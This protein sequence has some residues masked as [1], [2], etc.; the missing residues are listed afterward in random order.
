MASQARVLFVGAGPSQM[1]A[2]RHARTLGYEPYAA[3]ADPSAVGFEFAV[4][5]DI[6]DIRDPEFVKA[7][8]RRR[9][10]DAI[11]A[12]ATDVAVPAVA[13]A[14]NSLGL[15]SISVE[16]AD[17]SVNKLMQRQRMNAAGLPVPAFRPFSSVDEASANAQEIGFPVVVKPIDAAGSRGVR[18]IQNMDD[19]GRAAE[20]ALAAS[21]AKIGV[22]EEFV[23]GEEVSVEGF[24]VDGV[25][26]AICI[27]EKTRT[28]PP[29]L[30][31]VAVRFPDALSPAERAAIIATAGRAVASCGLDNC[32]VHMELLRSAR[33]PVVVEL[34]A[35]GAGFRVFT[36]ILPY[37]TGVD[38][39]DVQLK[40]ALGKPV[41]ISPRNPP[42]GAVII[43]LAP[44]PGKLK[45]VEGLYKARELAGVQEAEVYIR[46]GAVMGELTCGADRIG[47]L[48]VFAESR[49][50]AE[51]QA[52]RAQALI[53]FEV[54]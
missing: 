23:E 4:G 6:G 38:T 43:F 26:H 33:G 24:V 28:R 36:N 3:D 40:L 49:K 11:V 48:I 47:H 25:F 54:E 45:C 34:A 32:P 35:R 12:I 8:A 39:V 10:V 21:R 19:V 53:R 46:P 42:K 52:R 27:S 15:P 20:E 7:C 29:Y 51:A 37:V 41:R 1:P 9:N 30:L 22:V 16:A 31:D 18:L 13:R 44:M 17:V 2:I 14:C 5:F 50:D